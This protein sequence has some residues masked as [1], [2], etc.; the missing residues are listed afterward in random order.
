MN[1]K[2]KN[3]ISHAYDDDNGFTYVLY[4]PEGRV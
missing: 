3:N 2:I 1:K 4:I